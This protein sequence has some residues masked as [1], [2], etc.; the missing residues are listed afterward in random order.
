[1]RRY[2]LVA[3]TLLMLNAC[4]VSEMD[5]VTVVPSEPAQVAAETVI[6]TNS[7]EPTSVYTPTLTTED[8]ADLDF[9][10]TEISPPTSL[11]DVNVCKDVF[12]IPTSEC[13]AL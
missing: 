12:E 3:L 2:L 8:T 10:T 6:A 9:S 1:M 5:T 7:S 4:T 13:T 11:P